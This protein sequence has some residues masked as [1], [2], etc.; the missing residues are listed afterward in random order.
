MNIVG[1]FFFKITHQGEKICF[2]FDLNQTCPAVDQKQRFSIVV[3]FK[4][5][6][7]LNGSGVRLVLPWEFSG[8]SNPLLEHLARLENYQGHD[9]SELTWQ[10]GERAALQGLLS[11]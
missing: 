3:L 5:L 10:Q 4:D 11:I 8:S 1:W 7:W 6:G 2:K 9:K